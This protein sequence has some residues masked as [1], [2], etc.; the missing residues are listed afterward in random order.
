MACLHHSEVLVIPGQIWGWRSLSSSHLGMMITKLGVPEEACLH[1]CKAVASQLNLPFGKLASVYPCSSGLFF[2]S[3]QHFT[4]RYS[5]QSEFFLG[6][7]PKKVTQENCT[8][9]PCL[10]A[11]L[12][13]HMGILALYSFVSIHIWTVSRNGQKTLDQVPV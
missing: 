3:S 1:W 12:E 10:L 5:L 2:C 13:H 11:L 9:T 6:K 4:L 8:T 7:V